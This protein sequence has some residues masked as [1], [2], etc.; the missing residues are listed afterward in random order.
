MGF[1][2][3][4]SRSDSSS[5]LPFLVPHVKTLFNPLAF[6]VNVAKGFHAFVIKLSSINNVFHCLVVILVASIVTFFMLDH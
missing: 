4:Y 1:I 5:S 3:L 6:K 2:Y